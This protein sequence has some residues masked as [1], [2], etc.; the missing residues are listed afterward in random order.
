M[1]QSLY[2]EILLATYNGEKYLADQIDSILNQSNTNWRILIH[3][4]GS[5]DATIE[6]IN[7]YL[8]LYPNK[9][10]YINDGVRTGGAKNN[11]AHLMN[12][13]T[14]PYIM[15]CDQDDVW[16]ESKIQNSYDSMMSL[17]KKFSDDIPLLVFSDVK[18]ATEDMIVVEESFCKSAGLESGNFSFFNRLIIQNIGQGSTFLFN[19]A[20]CDAV[21]NS[22]G[23]SAI[24]MHDWWL[25][26][27]VSAFGAFSVVTEP[28]MLYRQHSNS[29]IGSGRYNFFCG[30]KKFILN[31]NEIKKEI[32]QTQ[33]QAYAFY[34]Q[35][36]S[37]L[38]Q[39]KISFLMG[40]AGLRNRNF[41]ERKLFA[42]R[43]G[44]WR[45]PISRGIAFLLLV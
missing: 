24:L 27:F 26:L 31:Y 43:N 36:F 35:N 9:I 33:L 34:K 32:L 10:I 16:L 13:S 12:L 21:K 17:Q 2:I 45:T 1:N 23:S 19:K 41:I 28:T 42:L 22:W 39:K 30:V 38:N 18:I 4:D 11:F 14:A 29:L 5:T 25:M 8:T 20:L 40:Y 44:L 37:Q 15:L 3:D 6:I 7:S